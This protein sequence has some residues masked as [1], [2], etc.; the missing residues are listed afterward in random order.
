MEGKARLLEC[1]QHGTHEATVFIHWISIQHF[2]IELF[3]EVFYGKSSTKYSN[4]VSR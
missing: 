2:I 1:G 4:K 3:V